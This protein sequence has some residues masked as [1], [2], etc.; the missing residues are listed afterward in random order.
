MLPYEAKPGVWMRCGSR[1]KDQ[2]ESCAELFRGDW[3]AIARS[4][5]FDEDKNVV[6]CY[7]YA[8][9]TLTAPSFGKVDETGA[10]LDPATY[11]YLGQVTWNYASSALWRAALH[12]L[13]RQFAELAYFAVVEAQRRACGIIT[14]SSASQGRD[15]R[16]RGDDRILRSSR[17][18]SVS[19]LGDRVEHTSRLPVHRWANRRRTRR[20][21]SDRL[22]H[23]EGINYALKSVD[24]AD[25][26]RD[27][28]DGLS[29]HMVHPRT[30]ADAARNRLCRPRC[31]DDN[32]RNCAAPAHRNFG[33][34]S[35]DVTCSRGSK[36]RP[37]WSFSGLSRT[38]QR[39]ERTA[40]IRAEVAA[41]R[42]EKR[43]GM[44]EQDLRAAEWIRANK[45]I[46]REPRPAEE[47]CAG[48]AP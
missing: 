3:A 25:L 21:G 34:S 48:R 12:R 47:P 33:S 37:A 9:L 43:D 30:L 2:C 40:W 14:L 22:V 44:S 1:L 16:V 18:D 45:H 11:D 4:G 20:D 35:R 26:D 19:R 13:H 42:R 28:S 38:R 32:P 31:P 17:D 27:S 46:R 15:T 36:N 23:L 10:A 7:R 6:P 39:E 29:A 24:E 41:G 8:F 5:I